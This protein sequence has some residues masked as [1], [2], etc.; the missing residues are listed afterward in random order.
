MAHACLSTR[1]TPTKD[2]CTMNPPRRQKPS[3]PAINTGS[4]LSDASLDVQLIG[5]PP[6]ARAA[7]GDAAGAA[8]WAAAGAAAG[9]AAWDAAGAAAGDAAWVKI[10]RI[11][12]KH[13]SEAG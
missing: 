4:I 11:V 1:C 7:A 8:A 6:A 3:I 10:S 13:M 5:R 9:A 2:K 12:I